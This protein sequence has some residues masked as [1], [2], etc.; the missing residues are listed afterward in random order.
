MTQ[1]VSK[2]E[3]L[4]PVN[5]S[6][7]MSSFV[8]PLIMEERE[9]EEELNVADKKDVAMVD[10]DE[11]TFEMSAQEMERVKEEC[12]TNKHVKPP[13]SYIALITMAVLQVCTTR[14]LRDLL[15]SI[16]L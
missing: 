13:Y 4:S 14:V 8:D 10:M 2:P 5:Q 15:I 16:S 11:A 1:E 3:M 12:R 9:A 7:V 6:E